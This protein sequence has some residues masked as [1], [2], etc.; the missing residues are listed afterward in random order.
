MAGQ[1]QVLGLYVHQDVLTRMNTGCESFR[2]EL[3]RLLNWVSNIQGQIV[4]GAQQF[5]HDVDNK[6]IQNDQSNETQ[7]GMIKELYNGAKFGGE[8][9]K[10]NI[11]MYQ[12]SATVEQKMECIYMAIAGGKLRY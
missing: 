1:I 3:E 11:L 7:E 5:A 9:R 2:G 12:K 10:D 4:Q 6:L 8:N